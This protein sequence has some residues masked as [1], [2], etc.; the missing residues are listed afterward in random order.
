VLVVTAVELPVRVSVDCSM[1]AAVTTGVP[2]DAAM[3][4]G[5]P[6]IW[7]FADAAL[8]VSETPPT[9]VVV[10][11]IFCVAVETMLICEDESATVIAGAG[12]TCRVIVDWPVMPSPVAVNC[13]LRVAIVAL[14][15]AFS[16]SI[17]TCAPALA[18]G[19]VAGL[20]LALIPEGNVDVLSAT[21]PANDP[22]VV[23]V[24]CS[25]ALCPATSESFADAAVT[26]SVGNT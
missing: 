18:D 6:V 3:P 9:G 5:R 20:Q 22:P 17:A 19:K 16:V 10:T 11:V 14:T 4:T 23:A 13:R 15:E 26:V 7:K 21:V 12:E 25:V 24:T 2:H 1:P 8:E